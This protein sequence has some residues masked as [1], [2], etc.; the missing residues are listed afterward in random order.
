ME[1][2]VILATTPPLSDVHL[3]AKNGIAVKS[4]KSKQKDSNMIVAQDSTLHIHRLETGF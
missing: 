2:H 1:S 3:A 4:A